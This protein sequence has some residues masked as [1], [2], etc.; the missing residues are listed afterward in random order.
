VGLEPWIIATIVVVVGAVVVAVFLLYKVMKVGKKK[1]EETAIEVVETQKKLPIT[2]EH[3]ITLEGAK[4]AQGELKTL[5][6]EREI[7]SYAIRRLYEAQAE[8]KLSEEERDRLASG[9]K[10]KMV[11]IKDAMARNE[12]VVALHELES[13]QDDLIKLFNDRFDELGAKIEDLRTRLEI[14]PIQEIPIPTETAPTEETP[15]KEKRKEGTPPTPTPKKTEA[16]ERIE[17]IKEEVEKVLEK[18]GQI[19]AEG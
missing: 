19:E 1:K 2:K 13:M 15:K 12:S 18:L 4:K 5:D 9:Y 8:G 7:I 10:E 6:I 3:T 16:E 17:K 11:T 14:K